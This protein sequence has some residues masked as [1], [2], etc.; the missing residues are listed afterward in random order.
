MPG[1]AFLFEEIVD[2][3][4]VHKAVA[5][6]DDESGAPPAIGNDGGQ[7]VLDTAELEC[8]IP[9]ASAEMVGQSVESLDYGSGILN[10]SV[11]LVRSRALPLVRGVFSVTTLTTDML[12][13]I[14]A[15]E[16]HSPKTM[17]LSRKQSGGSTSQ[18]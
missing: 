6:G 17:I 13:C 3:D 5:S 1:R 8:I 7:F 16:I 12:S 11:E 4:S 18:V 14:I 2:F 9:V 15:L 10:W